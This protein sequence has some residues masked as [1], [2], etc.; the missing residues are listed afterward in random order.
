MKNTFA[1]L[2]I[3]VMIASLFTAC[4]GDNTPENSGVT[5]AEAV[6]SGISGEASGGEE[7]STKCHLPERDWNTTLLWATKYPEGDTSD[8]R[9]YEIW[10]D[11]DL[12][13]SVSLTVVQRSEWLRDTYGIT[14]EM[15]MNPADRVVNYVELAVE[16]NLELDVIAAP[17]GDIAPQIQNGYYYDIVD[18]NNDY[19]DGKGWISLDKPYWDQGT[20]RDLSMDHKVFMLTGDICLF[21]DEN[22][23]AM[24]FN[25]KMVEDYQLESPYTTVKENKWTID[26]LYEYCKTVTMPVGDSLTWNPEDHNKWG[27]VTQSFDTN[28]FM[29]GCNQ[30]MA[31]KDA[32]DLPVLRIGEQRNIDIAQK[33][34]AMLS[35]KNAVG[36]AEHYGA[37][38]S[39]VYDAER[40]IFANGDALFIP[41]DIKLLSYDCI[42]ESDVDIGIIPLPKAD[43]LQEEYTSSSNS[44]WMQMIA[45]P[46]TNTEKLEATLFALEA[47]A[48]YG[49]KYINPVY[50]EKVLKLQKFR[51]EEAEEMLDLI[52]KQRVYDISLNYNWAGIDNFYYTL[53]ATN[54]IDAVSLYDSKKDAFQS[55]IDGTV[56]AFSEMFD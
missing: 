24:F 30:P 3:I 49:E 6:S 46:I 1:V 48:W 55:A 13:D 23:W 16:S 11:E 29:I 4:S 35:D 34:I 9:Y 8:V 50:Y 21:D 52:F 27:L 39:G 26:R 38:N 5:S 2:L 47:M 14:I 19:N 36:F 25:K 40:K 53:V 42:K 31:T 44:Y 45:I 12:G 17:S 41:H 15:L 7:E 20:L 32:N 28:M 43:E 18:I 54:S 37:W 10:C 33:V 51:D 56:S 22:T